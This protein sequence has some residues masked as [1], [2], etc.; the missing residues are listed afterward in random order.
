MMTGVPSGARYPTALQTWISS[1]VQRRASAGGVIHEYRLVALGFRHP[2]LSRGSVLF[3]VV[4]DGHAE[5]VVGACLP[6]GR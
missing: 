4:V 6:T 3:L 1:R 2:Q 5:H